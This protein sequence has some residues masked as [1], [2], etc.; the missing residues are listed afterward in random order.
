MGQY[1]HI[2][3]CSY[4]RKFCMSPTATRRR[5]LANARHLQH[6]LILHDLGRLLRRSPVITLVITNNLMN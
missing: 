5:R 3:W 2:N 6:G 4:A 1:E